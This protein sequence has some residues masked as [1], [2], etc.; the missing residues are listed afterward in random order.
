MGAGMY[1]YIVQEA[2]KFFQ[3]GLPEPI[4][5]ALILLDNADDKLD[6]RRF[7]DS[8]RNE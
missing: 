2:I 6:R 7:R 5:L 4:R 8:S 3:E 1:L